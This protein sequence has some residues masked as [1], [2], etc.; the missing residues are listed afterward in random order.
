[1]IIFLMID[2]LAVV[3]F[4][5][6]ARKNARKMRSACHASKRAAATNTVPCHEQQFTLKM[7]SPSKFSAAA[8]IDAERF[9]SVTFSAIK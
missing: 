1:M 3:P 5:L 6:R 9:R 2:F 4:T 7:P 8:P